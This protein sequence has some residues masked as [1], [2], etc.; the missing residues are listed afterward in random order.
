MVEVK[1]SSFHPKRVAGCALERDRGIV[2]GDIVAKWI[3]GPGE[4]MHQNRPGRKWFGIRLA[5]RPERGGGE[6]LL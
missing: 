1:E 5:S 3:G 6:R 2:S 4:E